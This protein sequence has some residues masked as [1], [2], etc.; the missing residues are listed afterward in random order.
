[1]PN[2]MGDYLI[3]GLSVN[4]K[5]A[6]LSLTNFSFPKTCIKS[7]IL[8]FA[9][10]ASLISL[11]G[12]L[13]VTHTIVVT[14]G[15]NDESAAVLFHALKYSR[16][17][18]NLRV[19]DAKFETEGFVQLATCVQMN[20][21]LLSLQ[22]EDLEHMGASSVF[23]VR[24]TRW[25]NRGRAQRNIARTLP[26][27]CSLWGRASRCRR[28]RSNLIVCTRLPQNLVVSGT[29]SAR[30]SAIFT[31]QSV[32]LCSALEASLAKNGSITELELVN[33]RFADRLIDCVGRGLRAN[34]K[35]RYLDMSG[36]LMVFHTFRYSEL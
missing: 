5:V 12:T 15:L 11:T 36:S 4:T 17:I 34:K 30:D 13:I 14:F 27:C 35:L 8:A 32:E 31:S 24:V 16:S 2:E 9:V 22:L 20:R 23:L 26:N 19:A 33:L 6:Q 21:S 28:S 7:W 29:K 1:M 10:N 18:Q 3:N 25:K